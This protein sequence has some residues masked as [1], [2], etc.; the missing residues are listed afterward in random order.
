MDWTQIGKLIAPM[1]PVLGGVLGGF[2]PIPGASLAGQALGNVLATALGVPPT[3]DAVAQAVKNNPNEVVL[4][5]LQAATEEAKVRWP[6]FAEVEKAYYEAQARAIEAVNATMRVEM[7]PEN[8]HWFYT[9]WRP[10]AGWIFDIYAALLVA[11]VV[12][13][14]LLAFAGN[15]APLEI[16]TKSW[17][18]YLALLATLA[19]MVGVYIVGRSQEKVKEAEVKTPPKTVPVPTRR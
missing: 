1:A 12:W 6:A 9:G 18:I 19:A 5:Q 16:M 4:A 3:P 11:L 13:A 14:T 2:I 7:Q 17:P 15:A 8:R 10:A